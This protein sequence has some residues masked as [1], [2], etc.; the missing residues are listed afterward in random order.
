MRLKVTD[1]S[2]DPNLF[3]AIKRYYTL[4]RMTFDT[5]IYK[6]FETPTSQIYRFLS[7]PVPP[8]Q[9]KTAGEVA[10]VDFQC[11]K[12]QNSSRIQ[13]NLS[14]SQP[15]QEGAMPFPN[16]NVF[17]CPHCGTQSN[18]V[19]LRNQIEAQSKKKIV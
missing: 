17:I 3:D 7:P 10:I 5:N 18:L 12:C 1:Y 13:A 4:M 9:M 19:N 15:L 2:K 16:D 14:R 11:P 8:P 6:L